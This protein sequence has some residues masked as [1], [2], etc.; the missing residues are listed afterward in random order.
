MNAE[1]E[2]QAGAAGKSGDDRLRRLI[3]LQERERQWLGFELHDGL[4][5]ELTAAAMFLESAAADC[6]AANCKPESLTQVD[7][8]LRS[9]LAEARR[10]IAGL[11]PAELEDGGLPAAL[12][13]LVSDLQN[14]SHVQFRLQCGPLPQLP[15]DWE[16]NL[17]RIAQECLN[18]VVKHSRSATAEVRCEALPAVLQLTVQDHGQG[19]D[20]AQVAPNRYGLRG[21]RQR[22]DWM[23]GQWELLSQPGQGTIVRV[24]VALPQEIATQRGG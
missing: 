1:A 4:V 19:F 22:V 20:P 11:Q 10:L 15:R 7:Q 23:G 2:S 3:E 13:R 14:R 5:Q 12:Q 9:A 16:W 21:I 8:L 17:F 6:A 24:A 18:N